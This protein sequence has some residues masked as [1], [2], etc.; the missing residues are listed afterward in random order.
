MKQCDA[1][2]R[3]AY[4]NSMK[5]AQKEGAKS[6]GFS[7]LSSSIFRGKQTLEKVLEMGVDGVLEG[8]YEGLEEVHLCAFGSHPVRSGQKPLLEICKRKLP[9]F[10]K[11]ATL[12]TSGESSGEDSDDADH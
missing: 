9:S 11:E 4:I 6:I 1:L 3:K 5:Q 10:G 8:A 2:V 12:D 7:L